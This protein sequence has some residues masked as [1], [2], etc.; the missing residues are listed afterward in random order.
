MDTTPRE[1]RECKYTSCKECR[2]AE[3]KASG[4]VEC[5]GCRGLL[6]SSLEEESVRLRKEMEEMKVKLAS[7]QE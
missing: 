5:E 1:C 3:Y 6:F 4:Y 7:M 2:W